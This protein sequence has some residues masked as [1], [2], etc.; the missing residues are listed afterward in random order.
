MPRA[1]A[2]GFA[3]LD[4]T[5]PPEGFAEARWRTAIEDGSRFLDL[6]GGPAAQLGWR[7]EDIFG[8]HPA[9]PPV[10]YSMS[11]AFMIA[12]GEVV[13]LT[14]EGARVR[15][16]SGN[17]FAYRRRSEPDVVVVWEIVDEGGV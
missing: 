7:P 11:L 5:R 12:G 9:A 15:S 3:R 1:W 14:G 16:R 10:R 8:V 6:W 4:V 13:A 2:A 17:V